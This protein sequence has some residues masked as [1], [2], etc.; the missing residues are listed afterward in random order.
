MKLRELP[1]LACYGF[2][3][4]SF[5]FAG[6]FWLQ[7]V[8]L[9]GTVNSMANALMLSTVGGVSLSLGYAIDWMVKKW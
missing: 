4:L 1:S 2:A 7:Y 9:T 5:V 3:L 8:A 6:G